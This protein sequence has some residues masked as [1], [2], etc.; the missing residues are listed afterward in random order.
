MFFQL[1]ISTINYN[2]IRVLHLN[3]KKT[4]RNKEEKATPL[5]YINPYLLKGNHLAIIQDNHFTLCAAGEIIQ[6]KRTM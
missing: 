5:H 4:K 2:C 1:L 6:L 3:L